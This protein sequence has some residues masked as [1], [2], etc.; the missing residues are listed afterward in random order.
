MLSQIREEHSPV[1]G[2]CWPLFSYNLVIPHRLYLCSMGGEWTFISELHTYQERIKQS[3]CACV[4]S[5]YGRGLFLINVMKSSNG[6]NKW[7]LPM[8]ELPGRQHRPL[9]FPCLSIQ[10]ANSESSVSWSLHEDTTMGPPSQGIYL[11]LPWT[12]HLRVYQT[13]TTNYP[14]SRV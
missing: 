2:G 3:Y 13:Y 8:T 5:R 12:E 10:Y 9:D 7:Q 4:I 11:P 6:E 1:P 14:R